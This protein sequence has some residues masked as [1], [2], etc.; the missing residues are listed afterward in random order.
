MWYDVL[1]IGVTSS[2]VAIPAAYINAWGARVAMC[3]F[4]ELGQAEF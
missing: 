4:D 1:Y 2:K 3:S